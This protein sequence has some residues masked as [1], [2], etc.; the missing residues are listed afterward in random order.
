MIAN[1]AFEQNL[2]DSTNNML[3]NQIYNNKKILK[4][5]TDQKMCYNS[6][7]QKRMKDYVSE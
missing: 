3:D 7:K 5:H 1:N 4:Q 6:T 2:I